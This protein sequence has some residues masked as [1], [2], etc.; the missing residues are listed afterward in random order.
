[1][2]KKL[3]GIC[4]CCCFLASCS[5]FTGV[6]DVNS[7]NGKVIGGSPSKQLRKDHKRTDKKQAKAYNRELKKR[8]KRLGTTKK[9]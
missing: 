2:I 9:R 8:A 5:I 3:L 6:E 4:L 1:M 7:R